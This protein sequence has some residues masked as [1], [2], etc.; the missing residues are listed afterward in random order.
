MT[1]QFSA[2][3][4]KRALKSLEFKELARL[5]RMHKRFNSEHRLKG[6]FH[7]PDGY[8]EH[9]GRLYRRI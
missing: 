1:N 7:I 4:Q 9:R 2:Q 8:E 6:F 3:F 5:G